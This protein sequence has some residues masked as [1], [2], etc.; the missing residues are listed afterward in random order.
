MDRISIATSL[1][2]L[3]AIADGEG[4]CNKIIVLGYAGWL[5]G[6]LEREIQ[7]NVWLSGPARLEVIFNTPSRQRW[8]SAVGLLGVDVWQLSPEVGHA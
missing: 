5:P 7:D 2:I 4:P 8:H 1:D 3:D 6:Q